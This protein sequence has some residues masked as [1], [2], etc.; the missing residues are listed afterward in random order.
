MSPGKCWKPVIQQIHEGKLKNVFRNSQKSSEEDPGVGRV[1]RLVLPRE[2]C[3]IITK[4]EL[5]RQ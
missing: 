2:N 5:A 4:R 3:A 1:V